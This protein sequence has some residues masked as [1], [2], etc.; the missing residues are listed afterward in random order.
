M[1]NIVHNVKSK[2]TG[3]HSPNRSGGDHSAASNHHNEVK[4]NS[5]KDS[6]EPTFSILPHPAKTNDPADL[7]PPGGLR[8]NGP[9]DAFNTP[10]PYVPKDDIKNNI[11][12]PASREELQARQAALRSEVPG[13]GNQQGNIL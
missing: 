7:Q 6:N 1:S 10:G 13:H 12:A 5:G 9:M 4:G 11:P 8:H 3:S 2:L